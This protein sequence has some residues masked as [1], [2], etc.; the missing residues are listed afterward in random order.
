MGQIYGFDS[1]MKS[2]ENA[3]EIWSVSKKRKKIGISAFHEISYLC[4][5][6]ELFLFCYKYWFKFINS[7]IDFVKVT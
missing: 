3:L 1:K 6:S 4:F 2:Q 5:E 7:L